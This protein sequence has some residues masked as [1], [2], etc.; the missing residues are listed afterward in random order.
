MRVYL[1]R[2]LQAHGI[3][4]FVRPRLAVEVIRQLD[5]QLARLGLSEHVIKMDR[6]RS[7]NV[8]IVLSRADDRLVNR[9]I[10]IRINGLAEEVRIVNKPVKGKIDIKNFHIRVSGQADEVSVV[11]TLGQW[12][13]KVWE[14]WRQTTQ[15]GTVINVWDLWVE[16]SSLQQAKSLPRHIRNGKTLFLVLSDYHFAIDNKMAN[17]STSSQLTPRRTTL[18]ASLQDQEQASCARGTENLTSTDQN[19]DLQFTKK[20][21]KNM[22]KTRR[23]KKKRD[24]PST[25]QGLSRPCSPVDE[26]LYTRKITTPR[27]KMDV[28]SLRLSSPGD[29]YPVIET[30]NKRQD[31]EAILVLRTRS[32]R[33]GTS[34]ATMQ[35]G[36]GG[37]SP[38]G[39]KRYKSFNLFSGNTSINESVG[40]G[41]PGYQEQWLSK[42]RMEVSSMGV[43]YCSS[44][45][46]VEGLVDMIIGSL[47]H[48]AINCALEA[49]NTVLKERLPRKLVVRKLCS[50]WY[51]YLINGE[52]TQPESLRK[53]H[54]LIL[55][56]RSAIRNYIE[57]SYSTGR[58]RL[59]SLE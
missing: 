9:W 55:F 24:T 28:S 45:E 21:G 41:P 20:G 52:G 22:K 53:G 57:A 19:Q 18:T 29:F 16:A 5:I 54:A 10:P 13:I 48:E 30:M 7:N 15:T 35:L 51:H 1:T 8:D 56:R 14:I 26:E 32:Q 37:S 46:V 59:R 25:G 27:N 43:T 47:G 40:F 58:S 50:N 12:G 44:G 4:P 11:E 49:R 17:R 36:S 23:K 2:V 34:G 31:E 38:V 39:L 3:H 6:L 42:G 33:S